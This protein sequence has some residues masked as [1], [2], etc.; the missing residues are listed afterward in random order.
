MEWKE[1][2]QI[3]FEAHEQS[4]GDRDAEQL[5]T[6]L[7]ESAVRYA[8]IR[9]D[10]K[11][12]DVHD[13]MVMDENRTQAHDAFIASCDILARHLRSLDRDIS[14]RQDLGVDRRD[15]GDFACYIH[16]MLGIAAR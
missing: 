9:T 2:Q 1:A 15:I 10:W 3:Y 16:A 4:R 7:I 5:W 12:A 11:L 14:W 8:R 13:R 6:S